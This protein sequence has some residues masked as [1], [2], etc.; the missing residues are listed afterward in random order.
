MCHG[1]HFGYQIRL[2]L[3][4]QNLMLFEE[5]QVCHHGHH[6]GYWNW[7]IQQFWITISPRRLPSSFGSTWLTVWEEMWFQ[8]GG[9]LGH[10]N[11]RILAILNFHITPMPPIKFKLNQTYR[12][13]A[14]VI[15]RFSRLPWWPSWISEQNPS[16]SSK[17]PCCPD[18]FHWVST[19]SDWRFGSR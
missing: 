8:D 9:H 7:M 12:L 18:A 5:F 16:S 6:P 3:A 13:G 10:W 17:S 19:L 15:W 1:G 14:D 4:I 11:R 2:P